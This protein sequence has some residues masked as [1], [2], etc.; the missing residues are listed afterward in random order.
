[1]TICRHCSTTWTGLKIAHCA[2]CHRTFTTPAN[3]DR[4]RA[5]IRENGRTV[6]QPGEC[7]DPALNG[8]VLND[9]GQWAAPGRDG[10]VS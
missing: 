8:L 2:T 7:H 4:H 1:M 6:V 5:G 10:A 3:F 9:R